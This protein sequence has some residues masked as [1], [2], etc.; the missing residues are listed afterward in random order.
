MRIHH[1]GYMVKNIKKAIET[2]KVIGFAVE[3]EIVFDE[4]RGIDICF[5][6]MDGYRIELVASHNE[7]SVIYKLQKKNGK[8]S[9]SHLL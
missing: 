1:V 2:F 9:I 6:I 4:Y 5:M 8:F 3:K 7:Y